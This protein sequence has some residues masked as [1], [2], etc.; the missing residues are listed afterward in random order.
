MEF[1][2]LKQYW[3]NRDQTHQSELTE[4][5][6]QNAQNLVA[7]VN[8]FLND[9]EWTGKVVVSSGWRPPSVNQTVKGAAK[10]SLH[11]LGLAVDIQDVNGELAVKIKE[12]PELLEKYGLWMEDPSYTKTWTH[13][14]LGTRSPR[15]IRIFIP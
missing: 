7:H 2:S 13:L 1:L 4:E 11:Q 10:K 9:L 12:K 15:P 5:I 8:A 6:K 14:D 3:M